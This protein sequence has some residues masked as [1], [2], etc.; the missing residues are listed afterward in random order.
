MQCRMNGMLAENDFRARN[1]NTVA[2]GEESFSS[3]EADFE[4]VIGYNAC[5]QLFNNCID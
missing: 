3:L 4:P 1:G 5:I 2:Y